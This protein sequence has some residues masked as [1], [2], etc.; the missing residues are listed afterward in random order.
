VSTTSSLETVRDGAAG[1][2]GQTPSRATVQRYL[3]VLERLSLIE[4]VPNWTPSRPGFAR[5]TAAP[6]HQL[7]DP[8][9]AARLLGVGAGAMLA[10]APSPAGI[11]HPEMLLGALFESL[12]TLSVR[13]F[14]QSAEAR[15]LHYRTQRGER[16]VDLI[17]ERTTSASSRSR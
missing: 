3:D 2:Q 9:F 16:E 10:S 13:I 17:V 4:L 6:K 1:T 8:A 11:R 5:L 7:T 12:V 15:V 14:A